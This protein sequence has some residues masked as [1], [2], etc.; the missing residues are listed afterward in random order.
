MQAMNFKTLYVTELQEMSLEGQ[1]GEPSVERG[2]RV[3]RS[4]R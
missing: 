3:V 4:C 1:L 2:E